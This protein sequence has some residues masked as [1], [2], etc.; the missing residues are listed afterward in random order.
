MKLKKEVT[1]WNMF[2]ICYVFFLMTSVGGYI[3]VQIVYLL[4]DPA[5]FGMDAE[6]QGRVTSNILFTALIVG[7]CWTFVAGFIYDL[8]LR[9]IPIFASGIFAAL[10]LVLCPYT[11]PS[12]MALTLLRCC[13]Q[14][15]L[16]TL[17][18]HPLIM[19]YVRQESRGKAAAF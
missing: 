11:A 1:G 3:N 13:I 18:C 2:A 14:I 5:L 15:C 10:F 6:F 4:R 9:K 19:D 8:F 7:T 17:M 12:E 16:A